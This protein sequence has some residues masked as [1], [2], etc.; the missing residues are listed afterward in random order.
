MEPEVLTAGAAYASD[1]VRVAYSA[2]GE[3]ISECVRIIRERPEAR[4]LLKNAE[5]LSDEEI[6]AVADMLRAFS[7]RR[8]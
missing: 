6:G 1:G 5:V 7:E 2:A 4:R 8:L 3:D